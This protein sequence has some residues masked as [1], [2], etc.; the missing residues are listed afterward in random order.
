[1]SDFNFLTLNIKE[2]IAFGFVINA[3]SFPERF[4]RDDV[5]LSLKIL[6]T[7]MRTSSTESLINFAAQTCI[8]FGGVVW[9]RNDFPLVVKCGRNP[10][11]K[12]IRLRNISSLSYCHSLLE[13]T[14][15][16]RAIA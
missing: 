7:V 13:E 9:L 1:M 15:H 3:S 14:Q 16:C 5:T 8:L 4:S 11:E 2:S 6:L 10:G 12:S